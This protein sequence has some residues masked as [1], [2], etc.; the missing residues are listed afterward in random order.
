MGSTAT[1]L[2]IGHSD[3]TGA[4]FIELL[5]RHGVTAVADVRSRPYSRM[6]PHFSHQ[7]LKAALAQAGIDYAF[8][9]RELGARPGDPAC[10]ERG[11]ALYSRIAATAAFA[12]GLE[13][14]RKGTE[15]YRIALLCVEKDPIVCHRAILVC[16]HVRQFELTIRHILPDGSLEAHATV[17]ERLLALHQLDQPTLFDSADLSIRLEQAYDRQ[18]ELI[19]YRV[20]GQGRDERD[21]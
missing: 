19:Q 14:L 4:A 20:G 15:R 10:Y 6:Y 5:L 17:E 1:L 16:R 3:H 18:A 12:K 7:P 8:L 11:T 9:G 21:E 2:T 13:R